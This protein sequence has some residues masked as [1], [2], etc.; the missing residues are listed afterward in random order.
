M[1]FTKRLCAAA[2]VTVSFQFSGVDVE[3]V[4]D[5]CL[6]ASWRCN[7]VSLRWILV[8][9][10]WEASSRLLLSHLYPDVCRLTIPDITKA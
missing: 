10:S 4:A 6:C 9:L 3:N 5:E 1:V 2:R 8:I 7:A